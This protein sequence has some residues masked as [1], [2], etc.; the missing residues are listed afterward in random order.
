MSARHRILKERAAVCAGLDERGLT[1]ME[2]TV[3]GVLAAIVMLAL[4]GFYMNSQGTWMDASAQALTQREASLILGTIADSVH[5][6]SSATIGAQT[7]VLNDASGNERCRFWLDPSDSLIH[8]G[9]SQP[10]QPSVDQGP[11][12][13]SIALEFDVTLEPQLV[14]VTNLTLRSAQGRRVTLSGGAAFYNPVLP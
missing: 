1:L 8:L 14:H 13:R 12:A 7:L 6:G 9:A 4:T 10:G 5:A 2:V 11:I 3:V